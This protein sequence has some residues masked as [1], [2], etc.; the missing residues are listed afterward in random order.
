MA[1]IV[2]TIAIL[3]QGSMRGSVSMTLGVIGEDGRQVPVLVY[4]SNRFFVLHCAGSC[5][6]NRDDSFVL[7]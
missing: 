5:D 4:R 6:L 2:N 7:S 1:C 3:R